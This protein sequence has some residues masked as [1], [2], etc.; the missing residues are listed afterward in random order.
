[1]YKHGNKM[2]HESTHKI[3][4]DYFHKVINHLYHDYHNV[5]SNPPRHP[6]DHHVESKHCPVQQQE[7]YSI[8]QTKCCPIHLVEAVLKPKKRYDVGFF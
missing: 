5:V 6:L 3:K 1:M 2:L 4:V 7:C 8:R